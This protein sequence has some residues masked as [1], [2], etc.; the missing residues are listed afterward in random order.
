MVFNNRDEDL[1]IILKTKF[2]GEEYTIYATLG[3]LKCFWCSQEGHLARNCPEEQAPGEQETSTVA[4]NNQEREQGE[5]KQDSGEDNAH[6]EDQEENEHQETTTESQEGRK[7]SE[8]E[9]NHMESV[10]EQSQETWLS[11]RV[12]DTA[13]Q[14]DELT[15]FHADRNA[16]LCVDF[17]TVRCRPFYLP[18]DFTTIFIV[19]VYIPPRA[20]AKEA[21]CELYGAISELQ[22]AHPDGLFIIAGDFNHAN[23][24]SVLP[25]F[26]QHVDFATRGVNALDLVYTNIL[27][28]YRAE[29]RP[30]LGYSDNISVMLIPAYRPLVRHSKL[31]VKLV[32]TWPEGAISALQDSFECTDWDMFR[33]A[34]TNG[35]TT[36][37]EEYMSSVTSYLGKCIDDVTISKSITTRSNQKPWMTAK[38]RALQKIQG[39]CLQSWRQ[40][41]PKNSTG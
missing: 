11:D 6:T 13:I 27:C 17:V 16:A 29:P 40:G 19:G 7:D 15:V 1:N 22:N 30:Q 5:N 3:S 36:Y 24:K 10:N 39:L 21:L 31:V 35:D 4:E 8:P 12:P 2:D 34:A 9:T 20:N 25:K 37:L 14:L 32:K 33:E 41:C 38:V 18:R 28:A 26:H 23:L